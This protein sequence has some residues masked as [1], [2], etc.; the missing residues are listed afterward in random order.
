MHLKH[1]LTGSF[2]FFAFVSA[3]TAQGYVDFLP[4]EVKNP[5]IEKYEVISGKLSAGPADEWAG[6]Y[7]REIGPTWSEVLVWDLQNGF[8][9]FRDTCSDGPRAW[10]NYGGASLRNGLVMFSAELSRK[11]E[12]V[13]ELPAAEFTPIKW[14]EQHW[15]VPS[16]K[17][18]LFAY[19]VNSRSGDPYEIAYLKSDDRDKRQSRYPDLPRP[20]RRLLR[21]PPIKTRVIEIKPKTEAWH[22][23]MT[24]DAG[25]DNG[26]IEGMSFW[27]VGQKGITFTVTVA[28]VGASNSVVR[29]TEAGRSQDFE[30]DIVPAIGWRFTSRFPFGD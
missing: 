24:I 14:G 30:K 12:F 17:L 23:S 22:P 25:K 26:V 28:E 7:S 20:L 4:D 11:D 27:V 18:S 29:V 1:L 5:F 3:V 16:D 2:V 15:L 10:V 9:A 8:A 19:A 13:L 21:Q 6:T